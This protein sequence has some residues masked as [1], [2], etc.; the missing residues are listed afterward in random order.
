MNFK[1]QSIDLRVYIK[2]NHRVVQYSKQLNSLLM[3][4]LKLS[5]KKGKKIVLLGQ[6]PLQL[7]TEV[8][9]FSSNKSSLKT[10][11]TDFNDRD[12]K[13]FPQI[14]KVN[15]FGTEISVLMKKSLYYSSYSKPTPIGLELSLLKN[16]ENDSQSGNCSENGFIQAKPSQSSS[17]FYFINW[18][19]LECKN[20]NTWR[21]TRRP[22][23]VF[24]QHIDY[25]TINLPETFISSQ[26]GSR[27]PPCGIKKVISFF[28]PKWD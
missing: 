24:P 5:A 21:S 13:R 27:Q 26:Y 9:H 2:M 28:F 18:F 11:K 23:R 10:P 20:C 15:H 22:S 14:L 6:L 17:V 25:K 19:I 12:T 1:E 7:K 8:I 3:H 4:S 16:K